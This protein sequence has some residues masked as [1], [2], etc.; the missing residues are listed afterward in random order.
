MAIRY[1]IAL[2]D[3]ALASGADPALAF[4]SNGAGGLAEELKEALR[5]GGLF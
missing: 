2:P 1:L 5:R 3:P 4:R